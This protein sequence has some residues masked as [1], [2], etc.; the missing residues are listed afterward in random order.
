MKILILGG[1]GAMGVPLSR[2]LFQSGNDVYVT[3]RAVRKP[4]PDGIKF[5]Q[6]NASDIKFLDRILCEDT[7][8]AVVDF[9][10]RN[11]ENFRSAVDLILR[12]SGQLVFISSARVYAQSDVPITEE[13]PRLLDVS[14][15]AEYLR[16]EE[17]ALAKAREENYLKESGMSN[18]TIVRPTITYN[19]YRLQLGVLEKENW[20]YRAL[21][22]RTIVFSK[23]IRDKITTMTHGDDVSRGIASVIGKQKA[24]GQIFHITSPLS[25]SWDRVLEIYLS[26]LRKRLPLELQPKVIYAD[27]CQKLKFKESRYQVIYCRYFNR[28]FD[29]SKISKYCDMGTFT[30]PEEGLV[31][32][33]NEFLDNPQFRPVDW[34]L[35][36]VS[37][38]ISKEWTRMREIPSAKARILYLLY[39]YNLGFLLKLYSLS[40][41]VLRKIFK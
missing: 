22:G 2:I 10:V 28:R 5:I 20:L 1:T 32:C 18:W 19:S 34:R 12:R 40:L 27:K 36:A 15:D 26:V 7:Y 9:I 16:T 13:T 21:H 3:S 6:G 23:D 11:K 8:D 14:D 38:R 24:L 17:Y 29:N 33:L 41:R 4:S 35:E 39:R 37:D 31:K 30:P 25:L